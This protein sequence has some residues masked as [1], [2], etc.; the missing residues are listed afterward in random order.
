MPKPET[1]LEILT[2][3]LHSSDWTTRCD[4]ARLLG[5]SRDPRAADALLPDLSDPDWRVRRNAAQ[6]LGALRDS[7][8]VEPLIQLLNDRTVTVRQ[9]AAV[10]LGRIKDPAALPALFDLLLDDKSASHEAYQA[11]RKFG[12]KAMPDIARAYEKTAHS[13]LMLL[14]IEMKYEGALDI[15]LK[16]LDDQKLATRW[17]AIREL[18]NLGNK[19]AIPHLIDQLDNNDPMAQAETVRALG[20]LDAEGTIPALLDLLKDDDLYGPR[21]GIY[22]AVVEAFQAF[23]GITK[24]I[25]NV[26]PGKFPTMNAAG[27]PMSLPEVMSALNNEQFQMLNDM[28]SNLQN[29]GA[30]PSETT[31]IPAEIFQKTAEDAAWKFGVMFADAKD[32]K[33]DR[34]KRLTELLKSESNL[35]RSAAA[36][37]LPWYTDEQSVEPLKQLTQDPDEIVRKAALWALNALQ[38]TL[39]HR[40]GL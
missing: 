12:K 4:A 10:A 21:S 22:H 3:N 35:K 1:P 16:L 24:E 31:N 38:A 17:M 14:L 25:E 36:L 30:K 37:T 15:L 27:T 7:R 33:Q 34:V 29:S 19:K 20:K 26:F 32:A 5:Q 13:R 2:Q 8:A 9:R 18:G 11:I 39:K 40:K 6:A 23:A 28:L